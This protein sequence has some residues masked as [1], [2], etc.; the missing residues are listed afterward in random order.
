MTTDTPNIADRL[1]STRSRVANGAD[2]FVVPTDGRTREA[3]RY[4]DLM[5]DLIEHLGG[6][7]A[8]SETR[9]HLARRAAA[10]IL[11]CETA[12]AKLA[13]GEEID[14]APYNTAVNTLRRLLRDLGL[15]GAKAA[16]RKAPTLGDYL[17]AK[18][19]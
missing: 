7:D 15:D 8:M 6:E 17:G 13:K 3:R 18:R 1:P 19:A 5:A 9:R 11:W 2:L 12:E 10:L 14:M 4:R 16:R